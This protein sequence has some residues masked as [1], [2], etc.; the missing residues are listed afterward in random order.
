MPNSYIKSISEA[1]FQSQITRSITFSDGVADATYTSNEYERFI[2]IGALSDSEKE[3]HYIVIAPN[4]S[5]LDMSDANGGVINVSEASG[6]GDQRIDISTTNS[7]LSG[8]GLLIANVTENNLP[9]KTKTLSDYK[10]KVIS[11]PQGVVGGSDSLGIADIYDVTA[12]YNTSNTNPTGT[13]V[14]DDST[15]EL[16]WNGVAKTDVTSR[17]IVD[18]GQRLEFYDH[19]SI[20]LNGAAPANTDYLLVVYRHYTHS[21]GGGFFSVDSYPTYDE[22]P[23]FEDSSTGEVYNLRDCIDFRPKRADNA[24]NYSFQGG[25][26]PNPIDTFDSNY[27]FYLSRIDKVIATSDKTFVVQQGIPALYPTVPTDLSNGMTL[28]IVVIPPYTADVSDISIKYIENKRYTMR[29]IGR[30]EKRINNLE[31]YTQLSL[32][33]KQAKDT[34]IPD[35]SNFEKFKNGFAVDPFTSADIFVTGGSAWAQ[36]R[37]GWW[38]AWFNGSNTWNLAAQNYNANSIAFAG[39]PDFNAAIDPINQELRAP[40]T[41]EFHEFDTGTLTNTNK[42]G[43]LV[44]LAYTEED[45]ITQTLA[46]TYVNINPFN[47]IRFFGSM[48]LQPAF[49]QWVDTKYLPA[50]NKIVDVKLPDAAD[51]LIQKFTGSGNASRVTSRTTTVSTNVVSSTTTSLGANVVDIQFVP[52]MRAN[53][54]IGTGDQF[55]PFSKLYAF[56]ENTSVDQYIKPLTLVQIEDWTTTTFQTTPGSNESLQFRTGSRT[57]TSVGTAKAAIYSDPDLEVSG[58]PATLKRLLTIYDDSGTISVGDY[59]YGMRSG[60][61]AKITA[62]TTYNLGDALIPD[63]YGNIGFQFNIPEGIFKTGERTIRLINNNTNDIEAQDSI[64]ESKYTAIGQLQTK[65][66]TILTTRALQRQKVTVETRQRYRTDP[67]AQTFFVEELSYPQGF[68]VSSVDVYFR[69]KSNTVPVALQVRTTSNG[70]PSSNFTIPF[71][72]SVLNPSDISISEDGSAATT[73]TFPN[74]IHLAPGE[75]AIVLLANSPDYEVFVAEMG[76]SVLGGTIKVDK[77]PYIGSLFKS[78]NASTW[79][80]DQNQDLKFVIRRAK[81]NTSGNAVFNI[82]DPEAIKNYHTMYVNTSSVTPTGT[83]IKWYARV[84]DGSY[85]TSRIAI[86]V[87]QD[88]EW[89]RLLKLDQQAQAGGDPTLIIEADL[90]TSSDTVSP[91]IDASSMSVVAAENTINSET[92]TSTSECSFTIGS[93]IITNVPDEVFRHV[94]IGMTV[95]KTVGS[96]ITNYG[97]VTALDEVNNEITLDTI[98]SA[99]EENIA[100]KFSLNEELPYA[101]GAFA[102][103]I[104]KPINLADGFDATNI[105]VTVDINRNSSTDVKVYYRTLATGVVTSISD[106]SWNEMVLE[107]TVPSSINDFDFKEYRYFPAA[108]FDSFGIPNDLSGQPRFNTFQIKIVMLSDNR[109]NTPKFRDLRIIALDS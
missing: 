83:D 58:S 7:G 48:T 63:Q 84:Y 52:F 50:V 54:V 31:Y 17:Y 46:T 100:L 66:E 13:V 5:I 19:G 94:G 56:L 34:S 103:Y 102:R 33:E 97:N 1:N 96:T 69:T 61:S 23:V 90:F 107:S 26:I 28:Y 35:A 59:V 85:S 3:Q 87:N 4:G 68:H 24:L 108:A 73:F 18:N 32:L 30:L 76:Q 25:L 6:S 43:D 21:S 37:W 88:I 42:E 99:N 72:E 82:K 65:Q 104:T 67:T 44:S 70:Y 78:Q 55:K 36:R 60:A 38:N 9:Y 75:Y 91:L 71:A 49:D 27:D 106:E 11:N 95:T 109:Q 51:K 57:G 105:N 39:H 14:I 101:G 79:T 12:I 80:A 53:T 41:V 77:Q 62:V 98:A 45:I 93:P 20:T 16:T 15:G 86:D 81:F 47:V 74:P 10:I 2:G 92:Y 29:D 64:S 40:F 8:S 89:S 22:I